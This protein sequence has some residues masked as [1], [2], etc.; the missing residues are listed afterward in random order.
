MK[1]HY[2]A[3]KAA[4]A[5]G[6]QEAVAY[7]REQA[8]RQQEAE[9][10]AAYNPTSGMSTSDQFWAGAGRGAVDV[11]RNVGNIAGVYSD[12]QLRAANAE[13]APLLDTTAGQVGN[14]VGQTAAVTIPTMGVAG[15]AGRATG[16][17]GNIARN[18]IGRGMIEGATQGAIVAGPDRRLTGAAQGAAAGAVLPAAGGVYRA[19]RS[20]VRPTANARR[21][22][23][24]GVQLTPGQM[25]PAG[26]LNQIEEGVQALPVVGNLVSSA[27]DKGYRQ[28]QA[29]LA[30]DVAPPGVSIRPS[31]NVQKMVDDLATAYDSA[32]DF[33]KGYPMAPVILRTKGGNVPLKDAFSSAVRDRGI[34]ADDA[35]RVKVGKFVVNKLTALRGRQTESADFI[36]LRS[37][38]RA[39]KRAADNEGERKL[40]SAVEKQITEALDSHLPTDASTALRATD[41]QYGKF[42]IFEDAVWR[43]KSRPDGFTPEQFAQSVRDATAKGEYARG[44][45][46]LRDRADT[47]ADVF[48]KRQPQ[49]GRQVLTVGPLAAAAYAEPFTVGPLFGAATYGLYGTKLGNAFAAGNT[50]LQQGARSA[51]R[52]VRRTIS[53]ADREAIAGVSRNA[54]VNYLDD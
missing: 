52:A 1:E 14:F 5:A 32:Y 50:G 27:R 8:R 47:A 46:R 41:A 37:E 4:S 39:A 40:L 19:A 18:A 42:K 21:L 30:N 53:K 13:D 44:G 15:L 33:A 28:F 17:L 25:N 10:R 34:Y 48:Q 54:L 12:E 36:W 6:D 23:S 31:D 16:T 3:L 38:I 7:I 43:S 11:A 22:M 26:A 24:E 29:T 20:G 49:T 51:E 35:A 2:A 9:D 45:G